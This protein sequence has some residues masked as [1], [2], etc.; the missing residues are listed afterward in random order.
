MVWCLRVLTFT[1]FFEAKLAEFIDCELDQEWHDWMPPLSKVEAMKR[2]RRL[3]PTSLPARLKSCHQWCIRLTDRRTVNTANEDGIVTG[4]W[5]RAL[6]L[7]N[8][9]IKGAGNPVHP[10][11][12]K[13]DKQLDEAE[14]DEPD[15]DEED[16]KPATLIDVAV[17]VWNGWRTSYVRGASEDWNALEPKVRKR[18]S[19]KF[20]QLKAIM[21]LIPKASRHSKAKYPL[22]Q[23]PA[24]I[25]KQK[26]MKD[27]LE[28]FKRKRTSAA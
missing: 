8:L 22:K 9:H 4:V 10:K 25:R 13:T 24:A 12:D 18:L 6:P 3:D 27:V 20:K 11:L 28:H 26:A 17:A 15:T 5:L 1:T 19:T 7:P 14:D 23:T 2:A 16:Q 21:K